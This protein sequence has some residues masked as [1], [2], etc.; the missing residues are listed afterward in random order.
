MHGYVGY[1]FVRDD[2]SFLFTANAL[3]LYFS[4]ANFLLFPQF[5]VFVIL[6]SYQLKL[7]V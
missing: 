4:F 2:I 7:V 1:G 6:T 3:I 5:A